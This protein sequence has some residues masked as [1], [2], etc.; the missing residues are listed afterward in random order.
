MHS[1]SR[2]LL[3]GGT[4]TTR[5]A[6]PHHLH[7]H[8]VAGGT[9]RTGGGG[10]AVCCYHTSSG[11]SIISC[12]AL[13]LPHHR[14]T[15]Q[16]DACDMAAGHFLPHLRTALPSRTALSALDSALDRCGLLYTQALGPTPHAPSPY[17]FLFTLSTP[18]ALLPHEH[19]HLLILPYRANAASPCMPNR[20][21]CTCSSQKYPHYGTAC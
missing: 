4:M 13:A 9:R 12:R 7:L 2:L 16:R 14:A 3:M 21:V 15:L 5:M 20:A 8:A 6:T 11:P 1:A 18:H 17:Y 19:F 10:R